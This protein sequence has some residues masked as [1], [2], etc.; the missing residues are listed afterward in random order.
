[1]SQFSVH[2]SAKRVP[3]N[4]DIIPVIDKNGSESVLTSAG[5]TIK[6]PEKQIS[7]NTAGYMRSPEIKAFILSQDSVSKETPENF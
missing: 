5:S 2:S 7:I 1:M 4:S 6:N 3:N